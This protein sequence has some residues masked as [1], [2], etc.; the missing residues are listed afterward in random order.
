[1]ELF[2]S[3]TGHCSTCLLISQGIVQ[4]LKYGS[5]IVDG[6]KFRVMKGCYQLVSQFVSVHIG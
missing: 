4:G 2:N 1:M 6:L 3:E 5:A